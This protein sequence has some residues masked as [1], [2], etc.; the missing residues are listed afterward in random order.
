MMRLKDKIALVTG[1]SRGIG[2]A[3]AK[4]LAREGALV[5]V[6]Y[7][8]DERGA[9]QTVNEIEESGGRAKSLQADVRSYEQVQDM[10]DEI[11]HQYKTVHILVNNAGI[12]KDSLLALT[13]DTDW[14]S[15]VDTNLRGVYNCTKAVSRMMMMQKGGKI[16]NISSTVAE[17]AGTGQGI[18]AASKGGINSFTKAIARELGPK[19]I[20]VNAVAPGYILTEMLSRISHDELKEIIALR[21]IGKPEEV[22]SVV[23]FLASD[24]A[25]YITGE[26]IRVDGG[27]A[28]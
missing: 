28:Y 4:A 18:Y 1:G 25:N 21:R 12:V 14:N 22:A 16:I 23:V 19:G 27:M 3:I 6:N 20:C 9:R 15:I 11:I 10:V 24:E 5:I 2:K 8:E 13:T 7:K 26:V 17:S